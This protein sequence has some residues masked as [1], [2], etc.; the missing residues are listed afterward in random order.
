MALDGLFLNRLLTELDGNLCGAKINRIH[1]PDKNTITIKLNQFQKGNF[2]LLIS[3]HPQN[4]RIQITE[5]ILTNPQKPPLFAMVLRKHLEGGKILSLEQQGLDRVAILHIEGRNEIGEFERKKLILEI[6]GKHSNLILTNEK[7]EIIGAIKQY[8]SNLSRYREVLPHATYKAPPPQ[9]KLNP[10]LMTEEEYA[11]QLF[12]QELSLPMER[13]IF[14]TIE[15]ISPQTAAEILN[16]CGL[17]GTLLDQAGSF[18]LQKTFA[19]I[20][21]L[22]ECEIAPSIAIKNGKTKDFYFLPILHLSDE[23]I[24]CDN[25]STLLDLYFGRKEREN[26]FE[27]RRRNLEKQIES[28]RDRLAKKI[29]KQEREL[30]HAIDGENYRRYGEIL[31][32]YIYQV[33]EHSAEVMLPDFYQQDTEI[34]IPLKPELSPAENAARYFRLY[35]KAKTARDAIKVHLSNNRE[36]LEY[37]ESLC[38]AAANCSSDNDLQELKR[39]M[40]VAGYLKESRMT[41]KEKG[42]VP[43]P[44]METEYD[45]Y[46]ILIGRNN[47]QND[48]LTLKT[49]AKDDLWFHTKDIPG[50]HVIIKKKQGQTIPDEVIAKAAQYAAYY[51]KAK[52]ADKVPVDYTEVKQVK[53]PSGARPGMVIYFEQTTLFVRPEAPVIKAPMKKGR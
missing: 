41:K 13:A 52:E 8:G 10:F 21:K 12:Q 15:G 51:S 6:M 34:A 31:S 29:E 16:R 3:C 46:T 30:S 23:Q 40:A 48:K 50:S 38:Y 17:T 11:E 35:N 44:P 43:L 47:K 4:A 45:G 19:A 5:E 26:A 32:A 25:L 39:E 20:K 9:N 42:D 27:S 37:V 33:P 7:E 36:E 49:A 22:T 24:A 28:F 1:Q 18:E 53:K 14:Q 2:T